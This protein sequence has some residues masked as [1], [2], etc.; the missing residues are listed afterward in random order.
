MTSVANI[1]RD[2]TRRVTASLTTDERVTQALRLGD[3]DLASYAVSHGLARD[4]AKHALARARQAGRQ[5]SG[6]ARASI[7]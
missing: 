5:P 2:E 4:A 1:L 6:C 3:D 7:S